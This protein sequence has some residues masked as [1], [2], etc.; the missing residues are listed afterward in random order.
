MLEPWVVQSA[1]L[2][3]TLFLLFY[4]CENVGPQGLLAVTL[5]AAVGST[6]CQISGLAALLQVLSA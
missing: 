4:L 6:I 5:P 1:L 3:P 2:P